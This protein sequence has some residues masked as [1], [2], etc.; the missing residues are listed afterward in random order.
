MKI[1]L[2]QRVLFH[3]G[4][5]YD[6]TEHGWYRYLKDHTLVPIPNRVD[7]DFTALAKELD[8]LIITGGDDSPIRRVIELRLAA[9]MM[10]QYKP[11]LGVC[12]GSFLLQSI[13]GGVII[14]VDGHHTTT[15]E[16]MYFENSITVNSYH[17]NA[18][19]QIHK[20]GTVL[21]TDLDGNCEAW[22]DGNLAGVSWHPERMIPPW[23]P[24]EIQNLLFKDVK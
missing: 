3:N 21:C 17:N 1:G 13:L 23:M 11:I 20:I 6:S 10:E 15:H 16:V 5:A 7:Q 14:D 24:D 2:S 9:S 18:I 19:K 22:I 12:H 8:M 4:T